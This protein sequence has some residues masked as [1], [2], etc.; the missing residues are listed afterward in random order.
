MLP[1]LN[2]TLEKIMNSFFFVFW[3]NFA[4]MPNP[5]TAEEFP[6]RSLEPLESFSGVSDMISEFKEK[7]KVFCSQELDKMF[8]KN[9]GKYIFRE[10]KKKN[11]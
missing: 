8:A 1:S 3:Q 7:L 5:S 6:C 2:M 4:S 11:S 10:K 9:T